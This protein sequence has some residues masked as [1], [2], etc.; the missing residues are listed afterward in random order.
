LFDNCTNFNNRYPHGVGLRGARDETS[1]VPVT[2]FKRSNRIYRLAM[3]HNR[4]LDH[5]RDGIAGEKA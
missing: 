2:T 3:R 4:D 1:G 5:D